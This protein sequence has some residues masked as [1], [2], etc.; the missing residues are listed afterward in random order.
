MDMTR[1]DFMRFG[2]AGAAGLV[3][4]AQWK[5]Y[6]GLDIKLSACDWS[7]RA[8]GELEGLDVAK[9]VGLDGIEISSA[10]EPQDTMDVADPAIRQAYMDKSKE[11]GIVISSVA[12]GLLNNAPLATDPRGPAWLEQTIEG[13]KALGAKVVLLAFFGK[14]DLLEKK[15]L[16]SNDGSLKEKELDVV[17]ERLKEAAPK[18]EAAGVILG[19]EN[20]LS[21]AQNLAILDRVQSDAVRIYYD[22]GNSTYNGYDVPAEIRELGDRICQIHFKDG[23]F[24]LGEGKVD[25]DPVAKAMSDIEYSGWVVLETAV[26][27]KDR[28]MSFTRNAQY[29]KKLFGI[30]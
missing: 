22:I 3:L 30:A 15:S 24:F 5:A 14:G 17:V 25:M 4:A 10:K 28:D 19:L 27:E 6:A 26:R 12:M 9:A 13:T 2:A 29:V 8:R 16:L 23:G 20:T 1:R 21:G 18:A 7:L 11:T